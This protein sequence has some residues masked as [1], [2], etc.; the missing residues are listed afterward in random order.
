MG[1][2]VC[3]QYPEYHKDM[4]IV[5]GIKFNYGTPMVQSV[6]ISQGDQSWS[7]RSKL[8]I[9]HPCKSRHPLID[10]SY[11]QLCLFCQHP[12]TMLFSVW[13]FVHS[14]IRQGLS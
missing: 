7:M 14:E 13:S 4:L 10:Q 5:L 6:I 2:N 3:E 11:G 8:N 12:Q 9:S 1:L